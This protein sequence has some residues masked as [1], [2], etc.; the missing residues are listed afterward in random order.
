MAIDQIEEVIKP[1]EPT[2]LG[3]Q[4]YYELLPTDLLIGLSVRRM[5]RLPSD[6]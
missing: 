5:T 1:M 6:D 2:I 4:L 3:S